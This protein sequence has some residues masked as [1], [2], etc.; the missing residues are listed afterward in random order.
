[1]GSISVCVFPSCYQL[2]LDTTKWKCLSVAPHVC[3]FPSF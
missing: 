1:M 2:A 3:V